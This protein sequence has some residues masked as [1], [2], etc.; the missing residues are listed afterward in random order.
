MDDVTNFKVYLQSSLKAMSD[1]E[2]KRRRR[3]Y[4]KMNISKTKRAF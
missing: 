3:K 2:K 4:K 1:E